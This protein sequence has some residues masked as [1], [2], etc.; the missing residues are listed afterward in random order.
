MVVHLFGAISS[1]SVCG[2]ALL[3]VAVDNESTA[4]PEAIRALQRSFYVDDPLVSFG[5]EDETVEIVLEIRQLLEGCGFHLTKFVS[6][7]E[8]SLATVPEKDRSNSKV[9]V[10]IDTPEKKRH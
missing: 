3:R 8:G 10:N 5:S 6:N 1:P 2:Y 4:S 9:E 7:R